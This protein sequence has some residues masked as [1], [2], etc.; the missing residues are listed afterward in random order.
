MYGAVRMDGH[1]FHVDKWSLFGPSEVYYTITEYPPTLT[2]YI[3]FP[4][5]PTDDGAAGILTMS[6]HSHTASGASSDAIPLLPPPAVPVFELN[7]A[8][9]GK[10]AEELE[11]L[12]DG[13]HS[14][15][16]QKCSELNSKHSHLIRSVSHHFYSSGHVLGDLQ[17]S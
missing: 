5:A 7:Q 16:S 4:F 12:R 10:V 17:R 1:V 6:S 13:T 3:S 8:R 11:T 2:T 15:L 9:R 14:C